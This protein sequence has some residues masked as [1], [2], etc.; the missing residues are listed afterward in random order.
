MNILVVPGWNAKVNGFRKPSDQIARLFP[1]VL[2]KKGLSVG[3]EPSELMR[4]TL[5]SKLV[6]VCEFEPLA[7]SPTAM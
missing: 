4:N 3:I 2:L 6:S 5:P 1:V 7:F